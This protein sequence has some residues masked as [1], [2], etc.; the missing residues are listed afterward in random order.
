[1]KLA[2]KVALAVTAA[3]IVVLGA[4]GYLRVQREI[5]LFE[6]DMRKDHTLIASTL[7]APVLTAWDA[8]AERQVQALVA[9]ADDNRAELHIGWIPRGAAAGGSMPD[10][11]WTSG[12]DPQHHVA[13]LDGDAPGADVTVPDLQYLVTYLPVRAG[14][15]VVGA[16][17]VVEGFAARNE[18][19]LTSV[20]NSV[21]ATLVMILVT[22]VV[23][24]GL[25]VWLIGHP[26]KQLCV[27]AQR[28]GAS[29]LSGPLRLRQ[30]DEIGIL[31]SEMNAMC[32]RLAA[33]WQQTAE[34][35]SGR[36]R[37]LEQLR[38][39]DRLATVGKLAAGVAH[40]LG[41]PLNVV[42]GRAGMIVR[43]KVDASAVVEYAQ[44]IV[45][46]ADRMA[47]IIRQ[48]MGFARRQEANKARVD[49]SEV[50]E[51]CGRLLQHLALKR[52]VT[53]KVETA[54]PIS[55]WADA[56]QLDQVATNLVVNAVHASPVGATVWIRTR[57]RAEEEGTGWG[58]L[59][60]E[61]EGT[62]M[63]EEVKAHAFEPFYTTKDVGH[64][65]GLGLSV[66]FGIVEE[67]SGRIDVDTAPGRGTR[68]TVSIP[69]GDLT[70][71]QPA[72]PARAG[73]RQREEAAS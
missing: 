54:G 11:D 36:V 43:G 56:T 39:A 35:A 20:R 8:G 2:L 47:M 63:T 72:A 50:A 29:D 32:D 41:T 45:E 26:L 59:V 5:A 44:S 65:S 10:V 6:F 48:L 53:L 38:H 30:R 4:F 68:I 49:L 52:G 14:A 15:D 7:V 57:V 40:E 71:T 21:L 46:Q 13:L 64:G 60:V 42:S 12:T 18:Y 3:V 67:H 33:S 62:G 51:S 73:H 27:K 61:D 69:L 66:V 22:S 37:A 34:E 55:T 23:V 28:V 9:M 25:G 16:L 70:D 31:A 58:E 17:L 1:M 24:A 19:V